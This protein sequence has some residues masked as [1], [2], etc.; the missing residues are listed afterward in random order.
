M[1]YGPLD[2]ERLRKK[3]IT[4]L[5]QW[6]SRMPLDLIP[7]G[8]LKYSP[9]I[10]KDPFDQGVYGK[11]DIAY[12]E[13]TG[14]V[15]V[16]TTD[17]GTF[18]KK[19]ALKIE[20]GA[21]LDAATVVTLTLPG[22]LYQYFD[23]LVYAGKVRSV[24]TSAYFQNHVI[25]AD[26]DQGKYWKGGWMFSLPSMFAYQLGANDTYYA[27]PTATLYNPE[28]WHDFFVMIDLSTMKYHEKYVDGF[29]PYSD[30]TEMTEGSAT[31]N[32]IQ[33]YWRLY[34]M[35]SSAADVYLSNLYV[36]GINK[37]EE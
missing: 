22:K 20:T 8:I 6:I 4:S 10:W 7:A 17:D 32:Y 30:I 9:I 33:L 11:I 35:S 21:A 13:A 24:K 29:D 31:K 2:Y 16:D 27:V 15:S 3:F 25:I 36:L 37:L 12:E 26:K 34:N 14:S 23:Y 18:I 1:S 19:G 28:Y 5:Y